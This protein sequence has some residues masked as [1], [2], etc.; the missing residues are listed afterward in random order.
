MNVSVFGLGYVGCVTSA[1]LAS[2]GHRV[3]G[4]DINTDKVQV[5]NNG[6]SPIIEQ[7]LKELIQTNH[8]SC[9]LI[10]TSSHLTV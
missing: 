5:I 1:C 7:G 2:Q 10:A 8:R 4:V 6:G 3:I 9:N